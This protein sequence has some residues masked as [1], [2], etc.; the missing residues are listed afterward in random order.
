MRSHSERQ[1]PD[2]ENT[3]EDEAYRHALAL[4]TRTRFMVLS[5]RGGDYPLMRALTKVGNQELRQIWFCTKK[6]SRK[7]DA[8]R[9]DPRAS[10]YFLDPKSL[11]GLVLYGKVELVGGVR[12]GYTGP[13]PDSEAGVLSQLASKGLTVGCALHPGYVV[14]VFNTEGGNYSRRGTIADISL[15]DKPQQ[16]ESKT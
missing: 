4:V 7:A 8:L 6:S 2:I 9:A 15:S 12:V 13:G 3:T 14:G 10:L 16:P 11:E 1:S 5:A